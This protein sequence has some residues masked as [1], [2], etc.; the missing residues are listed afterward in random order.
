MLPG[1]LPLLCGSLLQFQFDL[2]STGLLV[3]SLAKRLDYSKLRGRTIPDYFKI[4]TE[5]KHKELNNREGDCFGIKTSLLETHMISWNPGR[6]YVVLSWAVDKCN[7]R[8][9]WCEG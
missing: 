2:T 4:S 5:E 1:L 6:R 3:L 7:G 8:A 9:G